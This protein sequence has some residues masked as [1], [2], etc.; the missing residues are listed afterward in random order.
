[1]NIKPIIVSLDCPTMKPVPWEWCD[2]DKS[3]GVSEKPIYACMDYKLVIKGSN[4]K[5]FV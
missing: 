3:K 1:M 5:V 4:Y 2:Q